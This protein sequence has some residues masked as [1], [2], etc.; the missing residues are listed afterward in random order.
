MSSV[1]EK[2]NVRLE[3]RSKMFLRSNSFQ[4]LCSLAHPIRL[5]GFKSNKEALKS[6]FESLIVTTRG[7]IQSV[8]YRILCFLFLTPFTR[9]VDQT[10]SKLS[11]QDGK[12]S[13]VRLI[14]KLTLSTIV[15]TDEAK[16]KCDNDDSDRRL[17]EVPTATQCVD[18]GIQTENEIPA[19]ET[20]T[21]PAT[22]EQ[23]FDCTDDTTPRPTIGELRCQ[24]LE[25]SLP[26]A[27]GSSR[28]PPALNL[29]VYG[30]V[31]CCFGQLS[32][33]A[34]LLNVAATIPPGLIFLILALSYIGYVMMRIFL[35]QCLPTRADPVKMTT[36]TMALVPVTAAITRKCSK[37][38]GI[39]P[40]LAAVRKHV[41]S[42][43]Q[44]D[45]NLVPITDSPRMSR[46]S[47]AARRNRVLLCTHDKTISKMKIL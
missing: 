21:N 40:I 20:L 3:S 6:I 37:P 22:T 24:F 4:K 7:V 44:R 27:S 19:D 1:V 28:N 23:F 43:L 26:L 30:C 46:R 2:N 33:L 41:A 42:V 39:H 35:N 18:T 9:L 34:Y 32:V 16:E 8:T 17:V 14:L 15:S 31:V 12:F 29:L 45:S 25:N 36:T 38:K 11:G 13:T 5:K 47:N 10:L